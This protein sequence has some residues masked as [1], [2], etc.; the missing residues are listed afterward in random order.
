M[1]LRKRNR[2]NAMRLTQR[3]ALP[4]FIEH[5]FDAVTVGQIAAEVEMAASTIY[6]HFETKEAIVLWDEHDAAIDDALEAL[7]STRLP[8]LAAMRTAFVA[9]LGGRYDADFAFQ[10][11][12]VKYIYATEQVHAAAVQADLRDRDE[13]TKGLRH[14]LSKDAKAAAPLLAGAALLALDI[15]FDRWQAADGED[16]LGELIDAEFERLEALADLR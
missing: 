5:G 8:P 12:R 7:R 6:R 11:A 14:Y 3:T 15:A 1:S 13:L 16:P 9:D 2:H 4:L 10:L